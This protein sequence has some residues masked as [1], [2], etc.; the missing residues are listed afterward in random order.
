MKQVGNGHTPSGMEKDCTGSLRP[1][2]TLR[3]NEEEGEE[4]EGR[5]RRKARPYC[6]PR[7]TRSPHNKC[8]LLMCDQ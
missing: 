4:E 6:V 1:Q 8:S 2:Q 5:R 7:N 3:F